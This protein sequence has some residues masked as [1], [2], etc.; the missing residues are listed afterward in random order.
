MAYFDANATVGVSPLARTVYAASCAELWGNPASLHFEGRRASGV[1]DLAR[2]RLAQL[3]G[4][5]SHHLV[6]TSGATESLNGLMAY[7]AREPEHHLIITATDHSAAFES[8]AYN[9]QGR[10]T[11]LPVD[12]SG[13]LDSDALHKALRRLGPRALFSLQTAHQETGVLQNHLPI[14]KLCGEFGARLHLDIS[15]KICKDP[16]PKLHLADAFSFSAHKLG[17][18]KGVGVLGLSADLSSLKLSLGGPQQ[19]GHRA[20]TEDVAGATSMLV[21]MA[22]QLENGLL[23]DFP[24]QAA[25]LKKNCTHTLYRCLENLGGHISK[26]KSSTLAAWK[27]HQAYLETGLQKSLA[28]EVVGLAAPRLANTSCLLLPHSH[29]TRWAQTLSTLGFC[30]SVGSACSQTSNASRALAAMGFQNDSAT[31]TVRVSAP[32]N[33]KEEDYRALLKAFKKV[34]QTLLSPASFSELIEL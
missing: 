23:P 25:L 8:A 1:L 21:A 24:Q 16:L 5:S 20:G 10:L 11:I 4:T 7:W 34:N 2:A 30:V 17:G 26:P 15:Q 13:L 29:G 12:S 18:P 19:N 33:A 31:R 14:S 27:A 9:F 22:E 3:L 6:F 32:W 28:A